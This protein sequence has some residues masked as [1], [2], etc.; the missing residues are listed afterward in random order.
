MSPSS[1]ACERWRWSMP[2]ITGRGVNGSNGLAGT[3]GTPGPAGAQGIDAQCHWYG[4]QAPTIGG[5]GGPGTNG[6]QGSNGQDG[7]RGLDLTLQVVNLL[8]GFDIDCSGGNGRHRGDGRG[9]G[10]LG[11]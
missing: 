5:P 9:V 8:G 7:T 6:S 4:D 10:A 3:A 11:R 1:A 2:N